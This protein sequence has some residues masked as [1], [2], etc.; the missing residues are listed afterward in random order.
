MQAKRHLR[1]YLFINNSKD[2]DYWEKQVIMASRTF[3]PNM[4][5]L[6]EGFTLKRKKWSGR[7]LKIRGD[8]R[9]RSCQ[10][11]LKSP[12][13]STQ[14]VCNRYNELANASL[15]KATVSSVEI[16]RGVEANRKNYF[17]N[18]PSTR[19]C[20]SSVLHYLENF[21]FGYSWLSDECIIQIYRNKLK[22][23]SSK[24][25]RPRKGFPKFSSKGIGWGAI[26]VKVFISKLSKMV[27][28]IARNTVKLLTSL[29]LRECTVSWRLDTGTGWSNTS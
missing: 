24:R 10:I 2:R 5:T 3:S 22:L 17:W 20:K 8:E 11:A 18:F 14:T 28:L 27:Q 16:I 7:P 4:K 29:S 12:A 9:K 13:G 15:Y 1:E 26:S 23:W 21:N 19:A 6:G 25:K